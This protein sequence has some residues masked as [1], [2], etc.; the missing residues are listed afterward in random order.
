MWSLLKWQHNC[1]PSRKITG[2]KPEDVK[3]ISS[4]NDL[5]S[6]NSGSAKILAIFVVILEM[7][8]RVFAALEGHV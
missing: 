3:S 5:H 2:R 6:Q 1:L 8:A 7:S 4:T